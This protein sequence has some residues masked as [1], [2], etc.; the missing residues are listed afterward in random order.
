MVTFSKT[1]DLDLKFLMD[2]SELSWVGYHIWGSK[3]FR[4]PKGLSR[5]ESE[6]NKEEEI[7]SNT[8]WVN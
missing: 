4:K 1:G 8:R 6:L 3:S 2:N 5:D 7:K